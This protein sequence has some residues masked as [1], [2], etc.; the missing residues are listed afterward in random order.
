MKRVCI[1]VF[2]LVLCCSINAQIP[3]R[4]IGSWDC[5]CPE[6]RSGYEDVNFEIKQ[7]TVFVT[8][9]DES[10]SCTSDWEKMGSYTLRFGYFMGNDVEISM[11]FDDDSNPIC[12]AYWNFQAEGDARVFI[13]EAQVFIVKA[14][15]FK[16]GIN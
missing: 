14:P 1:I 11:H 4:F 13:V 10:F 6:A 9:N 8:Y 3:D 15:R 2:A 16:M 12:M 5:F 7:D